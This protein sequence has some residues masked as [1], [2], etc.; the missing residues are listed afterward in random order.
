MQRVSLVLDVFPR[1]V[2]ALDHVVLY[3]T[4]FADVRRDMTMAM[5]AFRE[6]AWRWEREHGQRAPTGDMQ[7]A[8]TRLNT[9]ARR[10]E[11]L[12]GMES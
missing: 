1:M 10:A 4:E 5:R 12:L 11:R 6:A 7:A 9:L 2:D 3:R 8:W